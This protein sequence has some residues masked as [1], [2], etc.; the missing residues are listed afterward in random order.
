MPSIDLSI[1]SVKLAY[2]A[3]NFQ[4]HRT[5]LD[6]F[7]TDPQ[8][9]RSAEHDKLMSA[10]SELR[11]LDD[12]LRKQAQEIFERHGLFEHGFA[13]CATFH[14]VPEWDKHGKGEDQ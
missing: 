10:F 12:N 6:E 13:A 14:Y 8:H 5:C 4:P 1:N 9:G 3:T 2:E 11:S 7:R